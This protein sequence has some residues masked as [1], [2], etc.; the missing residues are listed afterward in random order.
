[1]SAEVSLGLGPGHLTEESLC[2]SQVAFS[3]SQ[4]KRLAV[5]LATFERHIDAV[6]RPNLDKEVNPTRR[7]HWQLNCSATTPCSS[8]K[9]PDPNPPE[10]IELKKCAQCGESARAPVSHPLTTRPPTDLTLVQ[11]HGFSSRISTPLVLLRDDHVS[12]VSA[13]LLVI[14]SVE[15]QSVCCGVVCGEHWVSTEG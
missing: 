3:N 12:R 13:I 6:E 8:T 7:I 4:A 15:N 11:K 9:C 2:C 10:L 5:Y 1:M 14:L